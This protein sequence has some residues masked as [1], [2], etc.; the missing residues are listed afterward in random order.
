M[1]IHEL[2]SGLTLVHAAAA[3]SARGEAMRRA[4]AGADEGTVIAVDRP[5]QPT[6]RHGRRWLVP[7]DA[8][9]HGALVLRPNLSV[10]ECAELGPVTSVALGRALAGVVAPMT[11]L[12]YRWPNDVLL[13]GGKVAGIWL[14][15]EGDRDALEWLV[16]SW[17]VNTASAP[18][19]L[20]D[21]AAALAR[22]GQADAIDPAELL[23]AIVRELVGTITTWD[24]SGFAPILRQWRSRI[25]DHGPQRVRYR[26]GEDFVGTVAGLDE[27]GTLT[28]TRDGINHEFTLREYFF[29][30]GTTEAET[31]EDA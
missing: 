22:E 7:T 6:G 8:G 3:D 9:L 1:H 4:R 26:Q 16:L 15:A 27:A 20:G 17:A 14:D 13:N 30:A 24:E 29:P 10:A 18:A 28:L 11:E 12:H 23:R 25:P 19:T 21:E 31:R 2:P 5:D